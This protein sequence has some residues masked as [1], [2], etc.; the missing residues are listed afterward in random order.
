[1]LT[2]NRLSGP[3]YYGNYEQQDVE[4]NI[5]VRVHVSFTFYYSND[6]LS[7]VNSEQHK[8]RWV[9]FLSYPLPAY[10]FTL[11]STIISEREENTAHSDGGVFGLR[12]QQ[13]WLS[14]TRFGRKVENADQRDSPQLYVVAEFGWLVNV[15]TGS[16]PISSNTEAPLHGVSDVFLRY[17]TRSILLLSR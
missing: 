3:G 14:N 5:D 15:R 2:I 11:H 9:C 13:S 12:S 17:R 10:C 7:T 4:S 16:E 6:T 1:M 8:F